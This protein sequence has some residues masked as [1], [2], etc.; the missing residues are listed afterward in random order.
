MG[1]PS[2]FL[3]PLFRA[4]QRCPSKIYSDSAESFGN[5]SKQSSG[6]AHLFRPMYAGRTWG[7]RPISSGLYS[8]RYSDAPAKFIRTRLSHLGTSPS[9]RRAAPIFFGPCTPGEHGA[10]VRFPPAFIPCAT[11]MPQQNLFGLG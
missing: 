4:L 9:N 3:R 5:L 7:T 11:A 6:C 1:H 2:D 10:P 8:V